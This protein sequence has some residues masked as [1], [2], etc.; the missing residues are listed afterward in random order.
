MPIAKKWANILNSTEKNFEYETTV[1][2]FENVKP[3]MNQLRISL[4]LI[5]VIVNLTLSCSTSRQATAD[6]AF[7]DNPVVAHRGAFKKNNYP[8]NSLASLKEAIRLN[9]TGAEFDVRMTADDSLIINHD[10][11]YNMQ[12][13][14]TS[15]FNVLSQ[16]T[17]RNGESLPTLRQYIQEGTKNNKHTRLVLEIK[18]SSTKERGKLI[19]A[20]VIE[21][22]KEL[23]ATSYIVYISF[24]YDILKKILEIDSNANTQYLNGDKSP[25][26]LKADGIKGADYH[27]SVFQKNPSWITLAKENNIDLNAWTVNDPAIM[28]W[29]LSHEFSFITTDE[30]ELLFQKI[31]K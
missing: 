25:L 11:E 31:K 22:V 27:F 18:P 20:K 17:L 4:V 30:P 6:P 13:I 21:L 24:D 9:C 19:A 8:E 3:F 10:P 2:L 23:D 5:M 28:D 12:E 26:E 29:L 15:D 7:A 1:T 16:H 14:E